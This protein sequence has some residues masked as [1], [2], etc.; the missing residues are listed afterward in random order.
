MTNSD[1]KKYTQNGKVIK[2]V[3]LKRVK[4]ADASGDTDAVASSKPKRQKK[5]QVTGQAKFAVNDKVSL[6]NI[7]AEYSGAG[8]TE[9]IITKVFKSSHDQSYRYSIRS[10]SGQELALLKEEQLK[11]RKS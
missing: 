9:S 4:K 10:L 5:A 2:I 1:E 11:V 6:K 3:P 7:P 8:F